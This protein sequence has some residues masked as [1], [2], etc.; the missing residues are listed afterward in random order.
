MAAL[1][2]TDDALMTSPADLQG[3]DALNATQPQ[4]T[5]DPVDFLE[6]ENIATN[7]VTAPDRGTDY[8]DSLLNRQSPL[9][10]DKPEAALAVTENG[11]NAVTE[12]VNNLA[13]GEDND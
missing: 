1:D 5:Y 2:Y 8:F 11:A 12:I 13:S 10:S 4:I 9:S 7:S 6:A 3:V